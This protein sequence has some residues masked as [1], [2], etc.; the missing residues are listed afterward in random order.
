M[1]LILGYDG[2]EHGRRALERTA[3]LA[4]EGAS[5]TVVSVADAPPTTGARGP[6]TAP[7]DQEA[8]EHRRALD[9]ARTLLADRGI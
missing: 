7:V 9:D 5:V 8:A 2:S 3:A 6:A 1:K 4:G